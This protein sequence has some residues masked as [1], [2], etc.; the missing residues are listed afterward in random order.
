MFKNYKP[1]FKKIV[2][3]K[4]IITNE[5]QKPNINQSKLEGF[6]EVCVLKPLKLNY[7]QQKKVAN[8]YYDFYIPEYNLLIEVDGDYYHAKNRNGKI[9]DMQYKNI[10]NDH[11]KNYLAKTKG[12]NLIRFW[13]SDIKNKTLVVQKELTDTLKKLKGSN[14]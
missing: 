2:K 11:K 8:K 10:I 3:R 12:Y 6:F 9:N 13:E 14:N 7:I 4:R 1:K 5:R